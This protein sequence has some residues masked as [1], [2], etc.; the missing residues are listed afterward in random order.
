LCARWPAPCVVGGAKVIFPTVVL[1]AVTRN[2]SIE[3]CGA[4]GAGQARRREQA[5]GAEEQATR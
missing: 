5:R 4:S 3:V 1:M 2:L